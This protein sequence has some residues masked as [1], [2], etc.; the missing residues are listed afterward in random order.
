MSFRSSLILP[1]LAATALVCASTPD[2]ARFA[3][4]SIYFNL[5]GGQSLL[6]LGSEDRRAGIGFGFAYGR[7]EPRFTFHRTKAELVYEIYYDHTESRGASGHGP[8]QVES[9]GTLAYGRYHWSAGRKLGIYATAGIGLQ[10][11]NQTTVD[12]GSHINSTPMIGF[13]IT[14]DA[15][16]GEGSLGIRLLHISNAG[17]IPPN[18]GQNQL[19]LVYTWRF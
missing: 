13:G 7:P 6:I 8:N 16:E 18:Q 11:S 3:K 17:L 10:Y 15:G 2:D 19:F 14:W 1:S 9:Y 12:L 4:R 5:T